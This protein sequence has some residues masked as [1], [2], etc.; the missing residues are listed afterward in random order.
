MDRP[1]DF[2]QSL[3]ELGATVCLPNGAPRCGSC[4][5]Q[6]LCLGYHH[7]HAEILPVRAA[8]KARRIE[9]RTVLLVRCGE[10]VGIRRRPKTGL[11]AGLWELPSLEG[12]PARTSFARG[13]AHA[14]GRSKSCFPCAARSMFSRTLSGT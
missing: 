14:D 2:N 6:H 1:G 11:L 13:S 9:E 12:K 5:V 4:P 10:E 3:M 8:K 7:G